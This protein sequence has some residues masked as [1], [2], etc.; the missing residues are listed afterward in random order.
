[1]K[2]VENRKKTNI[3]KLHK[4][5]SKIHVSRAMFLRIK[6]NYIILLYENLKKNQKSFP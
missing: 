3:V 5:K 2:C 1:M 6:Q 4:S